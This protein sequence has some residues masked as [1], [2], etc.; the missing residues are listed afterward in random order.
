MSKKNSTV[1]NE[2]A[3]CLQKK[4]Q[5]LQL[6]YNRLEELLPECSNEVTLLKCIEILEK[7]AEKLS[8]EEK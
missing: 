3:K 6:C 8:D 4:E 1:K 5:I 7:Q 2:E